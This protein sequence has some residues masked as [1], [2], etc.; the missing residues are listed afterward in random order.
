VGFVRAVEERR[1][2]ALILS[3]ITFLALVAF[4]WNQVERERESHS[5]LESAGAVR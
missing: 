2:G 3:A 5:H 4:A 1:A